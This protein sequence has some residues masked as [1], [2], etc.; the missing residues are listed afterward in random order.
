MKHA[1]I[2]TLVV[3]LIAGCRAEPS[4][5]AAAGDP[6]RPDVAVTPVPAP[7]GTAEPAPG[8]PLQPGAPSP[9][10]RPEAERPEWDSDRARAIWADAQ[11]R[12]ATFR[13]IGQ[14][15]GWHLEIF[16]GERI[17]FV[18][19]YGARTVET[20]WPPPVV[21]PETEAVVLNATAAGQSLGV[22]TRRAPCQDTMSGEPFEF[23]V[24]VTLD[25]REFSGCG[26]PLR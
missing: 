21:D 7:P 3:L 23:T 2:A 17:V 18:T 20:P 1:A 25:G 11:R 9:D 22:T 10:P 15:P 26:R 8:A 5:D 16:E 6:V 24:R 4:T 12:G 19:D 14:E 13:A